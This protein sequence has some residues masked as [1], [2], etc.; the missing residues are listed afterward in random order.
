MPGTISITTPGSLSIATAVVEFGYAEYGAAS[1]HYC[2]SRAEACWAT[3]STINTTT[4]FYY[5][6]ETPTK[7]SCASSCTIT[8]PVLPF[9]VAY[10][11]V[12]FYNGSGTFVQNGDQGVCAETTCTKLP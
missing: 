8:I 6:S 12:K 4:P 11:T 7:A 9:H 10:Y 3:A 1:S 2:G 5:P